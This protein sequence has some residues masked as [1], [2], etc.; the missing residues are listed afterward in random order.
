MSFYSCTARATEDKVLAV[1]LAGSKDHK[2]F[3]LRLT[4]SWRRLQKLANIELID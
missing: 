4:V 1:R 3:L 2:L